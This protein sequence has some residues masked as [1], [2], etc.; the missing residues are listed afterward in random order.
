M[1]LSMRSLRAK[2]NL[3]TIVCM[4]HIF[5]SHSSVNGHLGCFHILVTVNNAIKEP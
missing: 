3:E 5:F 2:H 4:Y 1:V